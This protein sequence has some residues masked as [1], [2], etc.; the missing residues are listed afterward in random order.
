[1]LKD[2]HC[3]EIDESLTGKMVALGGWVKKIRHMGGLVFIDLRDITGV[4]QIVSKPEIVPDLSNE[5]VIQVNGEVRMR[6]KDQVNP[7]M[8]T[9][10]VEIAA[11]KITILNRCQELPF[12]I[13]E[14]VKAGEELRLR[15]RYLDLRRSRMSENMKTR[16]RFI[17]S[18]RKGLNEKGF[19]EIETPLLAR[20][21]PEGA[22]DYLVPSRKHPGKFYSLPQSPQ[23]YK[24]ILMVAGF[25]RYYQIPK[26]LR[27]E[28][29]RADRQPEFTQ[30]DIEMSFVE[31]EDVIKLTEEILC[32]AFVEAADIKLSRPFPRF[33]YEEA[34]A[35]FG[36]DK[37]DLRIS[38]E[39]ED[40][41]SV[42][43]DSDHPVFKK[44][45]EQNLD[46][47]GLRLKKGTISRSK[48][49]RIG[50]DL[51]EKNITL[52]SIKPGGEGPAIPEELKLTPEEMMIVLIGK[53][54]L[55]PMGRIRAEYGKKTDGYFPCWI[56]LFPLFEPD[57]HNQLTPKHHIFSMPTAETRKFLKSN[58]LLVLGHQYD[59]VINGYECGGGSIRNHDRKL[60]EELFK[61]IGLEGKRL[62][63]AFGFLLN[64]LE[65]GAPPHGGIALGL[66]RIVALLV[67]SERI[68]DVI[69]FPKTTMAQ[70]LMEGS[71]SEVSP[72]QLKE[73]KLRLEKDED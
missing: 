56:T 34:M 12:Q 24:Q 37:P 19:L 59:I 2:N 44:A 22:R 68:R 21:T 7:K 33:S 51:K 69:P 63:K 45:Q 72:D 35:R 73:L 14:D 4:I 20:S 38:T 16:H 62:E 25:E 55:E 1:M 28:D 43:I 61:V 9:G 6:P 32:Q 48:L 11:S 17:T 50:K 30:V 46:I 65:Y 10:T 36:S 53:D 29:I 42:L 31:E 8:K 54:L 41:R 60:Q 39:I 49:D 57:E 23:L 66:D 52:V 40:L 3:G 26:C 27:D 15:Y 71:P 5:S 13:E 70:G 58:P 64:A 18:I 67:G 47:R